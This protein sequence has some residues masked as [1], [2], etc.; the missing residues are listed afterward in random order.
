L[1]MKATVLTA[2]GGLG[3]DESQLADSAKIRASKQM[4][5]SWIDLFMARVSCERTEATDI[6][7]CS[8]SWLL[9]S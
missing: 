9:P 7:F 3:A 6:T 8:P 4:N 5:L 1:V 2:F